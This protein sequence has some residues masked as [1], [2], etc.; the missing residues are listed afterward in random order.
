M[1]K[2]RKR[3]VIRILPI[4]LIFIRS[5]ALADMAWE[6]SPGPESAD[7]NLTWLFWITLISVFGLIWLFAKARML[8]S[9]DEYRSGW[10][11]IIPFHGRYLEYKYYWDIKY[12]WINFG[13]MFLAFVLTIAAWHVIYTPL[14]VWVVITIRMRM[15]TLE[16]F[17][18][19]KFLV[20][21]EFLGLGIVLDCIC[22]LASRRIEEDSKPNADTVRTDTKQPVIP[23][24]ASEPKLSDSGIGPMMSKIPTKIW[25]S[26]VLFLT[27]FELFFYQ[28]NKDN[29][30]IWMMQTVQ[31]LTEQVQTAVAAAETYAAETTKTP[32][33]S[34]YY[35]GDIITFGSYEQ[36]EWSGT[37]P[38]EWQVLAIENGRALLLSRYGLET[39]MF[40]NTMADITWDNSDLRNW[41][42]GSFYNNSFTSSEKARIQKVWNSNPDNTENGIEGP[43]DTQDNIFLLS[44]DE[45]KKYLLTDSSRLCEA[46]YHAKQNGA[47]V[48]PDGYSSWWLRTPSR[49]RQRNAFVLANGSV[50]GG[51]I[52]AN[53][54]FVV[55]PALWLNL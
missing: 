40:H 37:D 54:D 4:L 42:N 20:L 26:L 30:K 1:R 21:L 10:Q 55:R 49:R 11:I 46:T 51:T 6:P 7:T 36:D 28:K 12:Y 16:A 3:P 25:V 38:I 23:S 35:I 18:Q 52:V 41:L 14:A 17:G 29:Q 32:S 48:N 33:P 5:R 50:S 2:I 22:A 8:K 31:V 34:G 27:I 9:Y 47:L 19:N 24:S 43:N 53:E 44:I 45:A 15:K 13:V 39:K